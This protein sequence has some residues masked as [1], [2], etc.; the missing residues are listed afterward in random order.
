MRQQFRVQGR[1]PSGDDR[2]VLVDL[3][4]MEST[5]SFRPGQWL[6]LR[7]PHEGRELVRAYSLLEPDRVSLCL[8]VVPGG[9]VSPRLA[10]LQPGALLEGAGPAGNFV[11]PDPLPQQIIFCARFTG[12]VPVH[13]LLCHLARLPGRPQAQLL[14]SLPRGSK[15]L[16]EHFSALEATWPELIIHRIEDEPEAQAEG[17]ILLD[18]LTHLAQPWLMIA[19]R[20]AYVKQLRET[21]QSAGLPKQRI[22]FEKFG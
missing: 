22:L 20:S 6:S 15:L 17:R 14:Y 10:T 4:A 18:L 3:Q 2:A 8:D 16:E 11:L 21:A 19:G 9:L 5:F 7:L 12:A 1:R 13:C